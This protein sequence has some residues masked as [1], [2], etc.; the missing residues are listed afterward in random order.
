MALLLLPIGCSREETTVTNQEKI[1]GVWTLTKST[2]SS[3]PPGNTTWEFTKDG[4][5]I[6]TDKTDEEPLSFEG[7]Y[8]IDKD[9]LALG[10]PVAMAFITGNPSKIQK[11]TDT[12][13][14]FEAYGKNYTIELKRKK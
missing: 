5:I 2:R 4:V 7:K 14:I 1:I 8:T 6:V 9:V 10:P 12:D 11:L 13:L 3:T